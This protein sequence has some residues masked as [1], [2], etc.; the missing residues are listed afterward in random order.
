MLLR[1]AEA[2]KS[3]ALPGKLVAAPGMPMKAWDDRLV[4]SSGKAA[5]QAAGKRYG[6]DF[7]GLVYAIA[8]HEVENTVVI[9]AVLALFNPF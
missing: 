4:R 7:A 1:K 6:A 8:L 3:I 9:T 2:Q 5:D